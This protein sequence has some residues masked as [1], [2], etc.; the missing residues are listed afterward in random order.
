MTAYRA[1]VDRVEINQRGPNG[2]R[3]DRITISV[4]ADDK[5]MDD[6]RTITTGDTIQYPGSEVSEGRTVRVLSVEPIDEFHVVLVVRDVVTHQMG[7]VRIRY[8]R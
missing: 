3:H 6:I 8:P 7:R 4:Y 2:E 1:V 5:G